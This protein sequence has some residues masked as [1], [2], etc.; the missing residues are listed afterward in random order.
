MK[1]EMEAYLKL[2]V[3]I[4]NDSKS[5]SIAEKWIG[6]AK[7]LDNFVCLTLGTA[8]GGAIYMD[9][10]PWWYGRGIWDCVMWKGKR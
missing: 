10:K 8:V 6:E 2:P 5:A 3:V 9:G 7:D 1:Q 4:E